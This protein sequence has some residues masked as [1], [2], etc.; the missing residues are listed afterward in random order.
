VDRNWRRHDLVEEFVT[1]VRSD[2]LT[3]HDS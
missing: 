3:S 2:R 1:L